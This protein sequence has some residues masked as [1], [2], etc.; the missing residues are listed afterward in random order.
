MAKR[1]KLG[2][3]KAIELLIK[4]NL[5][6]VI[7]VAKQYQNVEGAK[8]E[9]LINEGNIEFDFRKRFSCTLK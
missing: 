4:S 8:F 1:A 5:R 3:E 6:F 2:D 7:S 9:D